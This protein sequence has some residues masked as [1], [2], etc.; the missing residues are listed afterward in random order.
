[1]ERPRFQRWDHRVEPERWQ[2]LQERARAA[3]LT[4]STLL[5]ATF[6]QV[7]AAWSKSPRFT[8]NLTLFNRLPLHPQ[9]DRLLGDFTSLTLLEVDAS[10]TVP[11]ETRARRLQE[12][13]WTDLDHRFVSG[14]QVLRDLARARGGPAAAAM[15]V[16]FTSTLNLSS[17]EDVA[18]P[19]PA[20]VVHSI[21][22]TPQV[23][24]D[25]QATEIAGGLSLVWD[26]VAELFPE[27]MIDAMFAAY[28]EAV[29]RLV[30]DEAAWAAPWPCLVPAGQLALYAAANGS[31]AP[32]PEVRLEALFAAQAACRP[33]ATAVVA[34]SR[35]VTYGELDRRSA[36]L[37]RA[38]RE[39][40]AGP[41]QLVG[42]VMEKGWEQVVAVLGI[43]RAGAAYLPVDPGL[44]AERLRYLLEHGQAA[45]A[46]TQERV[47][48]RVEWPAGVEVLAVDGPGGDAAPEAPAPEPAGTLGDLAYVI[49]TSGSTGLP[50]GVVIDHR[51]AVNTVLDV[52]RRF[53]V[54]PGDRV[55]GLSALHFDLS[56]WDVFGTLAAGGTLVLPEAWAV[57]DPSHWLE[58]MVREGVTVWN[59]VPALLEMLV[60]YAAPRGESLPSSLRVALLSGDWI[61]VTLPDRFRRLAPGAPVVSL[62]G[63]TEASI[64]SILHPIGEVDPAWASIPYGR[65]MDNQSFHVLD[66]S[67]EPRP[68]WVPGDLYIG[69]I[70]LALG[71]W[72]DEEKTR[73]AFVTHPRTGAR[74]YRTGDLGRWLPSGE[75]EFLGREDDQVKVQG[76]RIELGEIEAVLAQHPGVQAGVVAARGQHRDRRLVAWVVP[77][78]TPAAAPPAAS[79]APGGEGLAESLAYL[80]LKLRQPGLRRAPD[81]PATPLPAGAWD[82]DLLPGGRLERRSHRRFAGRLLPLTEL[83]ALLGCLTQVPAADG[84][85]PR[86]R[87]GSAGS[88]YPVQVYLWVRPGR[89]EGLEGGTYYHDP[90]EHRLV[91]LEPGTVL[92][93]ETHLGANRAIFEASAF[94]LFLVGKMEAIRPAYGERSL[95]YALLEAGLITQLLEMTAPAFGLGLCQIGQLAAD[96]VLPHLALD[97]DHELLHSLAGGPAAG[98][99]DEPAAGPADLAGE[100]ES[101]LRGKLPDSMVPR[102]FVFVRELPLTPNG[103]VDRRA[104]PDTEAP[105]PLDSGERRPPRSALERDLAQIVREVLGLPEVG[106]DESFFELGGTSVHLVQIHG[107]LRQTLGRE[108]P[109]TEMFNHPTVRALARHLSRGEAAEAA[110]D[111][112]GAEEKGAR[113]RLR[114]ERRRRGAEGA[115]P[116]EEP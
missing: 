41:G 7:L 12:R 108:V 102:S 107:R 10:G 1:V 27:G 88:L 86:R 4:A 46:L 80:D 11:F 97:P 38:L 67:L 8:L 116:E 14:I 70:G 78:G 51:G 68:V 49:F 74:L 83:G 79:A 56:V 17:G 28:R 47:R 13:L 42:V 89:V 18:A 37:A 25:H 93:P 32:E 16:V 90:V 39:R 50:K 9:V 34:A 76:H 103:K 59:S 6:A 69:G 15:P 33:E 113:R 94:S 26:A 2:L 23:W 101:F 82:P 36:R 3:G 115:G 31:R 110:D 111:G 73:A 87:Y 45:V 106:V 96:R 29:E 21:T 98:P 30:D 44:P 77:A 66:G 5:L 20:A 35:A 99:A 105:R 54:G 52:N 19:L 62:G 65:A 104:L 55:L 114:R 92:P 72:R 53:G 63:A 48:P 84:G 100:L 85:L 91:L 60:E 61:P 57:R 112:A 64:W 75:I 109:L 58:L 81:L 43:L 24:L 40:G 95:A 71:Y 22:Q